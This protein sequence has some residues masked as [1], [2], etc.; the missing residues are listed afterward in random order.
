MALQYST[1]LVKEL[2]G[3]SAQLANVTIGNIVLTGNLTVSNSPSTG[4]GSEDILDDISPLFNGIDK[5]FP[6]KVNGVSVI[7]KSPYALKIYLGNFP[8]QATEHL[9]DYLNLSEIEPF[10]SGYEISSSNIVF[11]T[12]PLRWMS[13]NGTIK[14]LTAQNITTKQTPYSPINIMLGY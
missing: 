6:L 14:Y 8:I 12:P 13:F 4:A 7:P 9:H 1:Y 11:S 5:I 2:L 3:N 10:N